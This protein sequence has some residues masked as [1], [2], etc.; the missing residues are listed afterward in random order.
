MA[1]HDVQIEDPLGSKHESTLRRCMAHG[2]A[3]GGR[4]RTAWPNAEPSGFPVWN[5]GNYDRNLATMPGNECMDFTVEKG[6]H[7]RLPTALRRV[8]RPLWTTSRPRF[9]HQAA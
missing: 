8:R 4:R 9:P 3:A 1:G 2:F 6:A 7:F 5:A